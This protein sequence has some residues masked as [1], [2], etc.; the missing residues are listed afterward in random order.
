LLWPG[1]GYDLRSGSFQEGWEKFLFG[2]TQ[3][4]I[5][6]KTK[7][8]TCEL[9]TM[10]DTCPATAELESGHA[11]TPVDFLCEVA[12]LRAYV[13]GLDVAPHGDCEY[14]KGGEKY[15]EIMQKVG[16]LLNKRE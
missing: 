7:C 11:E 2:I 14:C 1:R 9:R 5:T 8:V 15:E 13:L 10:C 12:H 6:H 3:Q 16:D 4:K